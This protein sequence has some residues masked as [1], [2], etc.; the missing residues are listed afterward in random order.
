M[1]CTC[2]EILIVCVDVWKR[3]KVLVTSE[4][5][6]CST[7][8]GVCWDKTRE[9][10]CSDIS[11]MIYAFECEGLARQRRCMLRLCSDSLIWCV[12]SLV[13]LWRPGQC[14]LA[15]KVGHDENNLWQNSAEKS[16][17]SERQSRCWERAFDW[18]AKRG[19]IGSVFSV[20][21][22]SVLFLCLSVY[23]EMEEAIIEWRN[24]NW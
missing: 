3:K 2:Y 21:R 20:L 22:P 6:F 19:E 11:L 23:F 17:W 12:G 5:G 1:P 10:F 13:S 15:V 24:V 9:Y 8:Y 7:K 4:N 16:R 14:R 18:T